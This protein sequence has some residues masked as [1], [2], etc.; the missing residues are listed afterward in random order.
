MKKTHL[1]QGVLKIS[2]GGSGMFKK[3]AALSLALLICTVGPQPQITYA[4]AAAAVK[5]SV[6]SSESI[7]SSA[8][9]TQPQ[10][11]TAAQFKYKYD[12]ARLISLAIGACAGTY[13][14]DSSAMEYEY[15]GEYGWQIKPQQVKD[16]GVTAT[17]M[18]ATH[19]RFPDGTSLGIIAF[20]GS[21]SLGDWVQ[22]FRYGLVN[23]GG[24]TPEEF[25][26]TAA[27]LPK[28]PHYPKVH[29][30]FNQYVQSAL[31]L[32]LDLNQD[33]QKDDLADLLR[34]NPKMKVL[35]TGHSLGGAAA[36][37]FAERL[38]SQG[39]AKEQIPVVTFGAP[40]VG[41]EAFAQAYGDKINLVRVENKYDIVPKVLKAAGGNYKQFGQRIDFPISRKYSD[42]HHFLSVY[43]DYAVK[44]Y[45][46]T[47]DE[48]IAAGFLKP[49]PQEELGGTAPLTAV[50][51]KVVGER[52]EPRY[53][54]NILRFVTNEYKS[55]LP[56][57]VMLTPK[58]APGADDLQE[59]LQQ[60]SQKQAAYLIVLE[61][62]L[63]RSGQTSRYYTSLHQGIFKVP[64]GGLVGISSSGSRVSFDRGVV[65]TAMQD[66][67]SCQKDLRTWL[68]FVNKEPR[69]VW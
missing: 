52:S 65:Q 13:T 2:L 41:N 28:G 16:Q 15:L 51:T 53:T 64:S 38:I 68:P 62:G 6:V 10:P 60:A 20:R 32:N 66:M 36:T 14:N 39:V 40:A 25:R 27:E 31:A 54:P 12:Q 46:D 67:L 57:Y 45:Y 24:S 63:S 55:L 34:Q 19:P 42:I 8:P 48:G 35:I 4:A 61:T 56:R 26:K 37:L 69:K 58:T 9:K 23:Y 43:F 49:A 7:K 18:I 5:A 29:K 33:G 17:F 44:Y 59:L 50:L 22:D 11:L 47:V 1:D 30:G 3:L 21:S